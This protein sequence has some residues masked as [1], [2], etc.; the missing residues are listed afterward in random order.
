MKRTEN[1]KKNFEVRIKKNSTSKWEK[2]SF[3]KLTF[4]TACELVVKLTKIGC[5]YSVAK[6]YVE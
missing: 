3:G 6:F 4:D 2:T 5:F 1:N